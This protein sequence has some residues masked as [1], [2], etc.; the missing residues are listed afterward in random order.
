MD[1]L[2][3]FLGTFAKNAISA[4]F[5]FKA[6]AKSNTTLY[7]EISDLNGTKKIHGE[8]EHASIMNLDND[9]YDM[10]EMMFRDMEFKFNR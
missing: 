5:L 1:R 3:A 2:N 7:L 10:A 8:I 6:F 9:I 4:G